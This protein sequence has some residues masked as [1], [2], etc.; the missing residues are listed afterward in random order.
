MDNNVSSA[1]GADTPPTEKRISVRWAALVDDR[2]IPMPR[3]KL[4]ASEILFQASAAENAILIRDV[5]GPNDVGIEP[6]TLVDLAEGNVFRMASSC[7]EYGEPVQG[8]EPKLAFFIDDRWEIVT[9]ATQTV[10]SL[11]G[12][13][14]L[15]ED[16]DLLR[17]Y[18]SP[19]DELLEDGDVLVFA[20]G[21][22]FVSRPSSDRKT[23]IIVNARPREWT[24]RTITFEQ[25]LALA[26]NPVR[27]EPFIL[28]TVMYSRGPKPN[29]EGELVAGGVVQIKNRM[30]FLVTET[31]RS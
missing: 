24:G 2:L 19:R 9:R 10:A 20:D 22:V 31:D 3:R 18:E 17:D 1:A 14:D 29:Q 27:T 30:V 15:Q 12:L 7:S 4:A 6:P 13:F 5:N 26:F 16:T 25:V 23:T 28:Y 11:R 21:P 8:A